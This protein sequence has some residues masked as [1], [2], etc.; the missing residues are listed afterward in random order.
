ML[1][2]RYR[3]VEEA[4]AQE[5]PWAQQ[6]QFEAEQIKKAITKVGAKD[7]LAKG[8]ESGMSQ[9][10]VRLRCASGCMRCGGP[11]SAQLS[12]LW[13]A[14]LGGLLATCPAQHMCMQESISLPHCCCWQAWPLLPP[15]SSPPPLPTA[16][17]QH[18]HTFATPHPHP[19]TPLSLSPLQTSTSMCLRTRLSS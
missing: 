1:T 17:K 4:E 2:A 15:K 19:H 5:T 10:W 14:L 8:G 11:C 18:K 3:D 16:H 13:G 9:G 7:K 6:E 12:G